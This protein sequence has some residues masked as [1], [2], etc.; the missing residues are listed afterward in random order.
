MAAFM[1]PFVPKNTYD[2]W[3]L[4]VVEMAKNKDANQLGFVIYLV[5]KLKYF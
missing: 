5:K 4:E 1:K 2:L 3:S